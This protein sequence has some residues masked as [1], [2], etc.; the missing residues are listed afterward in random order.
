MKPITYKSIPLF[1]ILVL[2]MFFFSGC[3]ES[4]LDIKPKG[5][6]T[7]D[8]LPKGSLESQVFAAYSGLRSEG[9][10]GLPYVAIHNIRSDDADLGSSAGDEASGGPIFDNFNYPLD[11]WLMNNYWADHYKLINLANIVIAAADSV[12]NPTSTTAEN[13]GEAKFLRAWAYFNLVRAYGE[14][15]LIDF[16]ITDQASANKPK[17]SV[18]AIY[19]LIDADLQSAVSVLPLSWDGYPGRATK[20]MALAVQAKAYIARRMYGQAL[21]S[22]QAVIS[23]GQYDLSVSYDRIFREESENSKESIF[24]IQA[25]YNQ[26]QTEYGITYAS[27]QGVRGSGDWDLGWGWNVPN[28]RLINAFE[29]GDPRKDV[30]VLYSGRINAPYGEVVPTGLPRQYWNKKVYTSPD[31]RKQY[32]SRQGEWFNF[33]VIRYADIVL[34]AAEAAN[35]LGGDSNIDLSLTYLE[36]VRSRARGSNAGILPKVTSR[37]QSTVRTAIRHERQVELGMENERFFDL[38]RWGIDEDTLH[39]AGKTNYQTKN[40][41]LPIPQPE[42]D[43]SGGVLIQN[44]DY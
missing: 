23:S 39:A 33:R 15:P 40:R 8:D 42:I 12:E 2:G 18:S 37:D 38:V 3:K 16:R 43:K 5:R 11:Y 10:S 44:P 14:V 35:E 4:W 13:V 29:D 20:C 34:L 41:Y 22:A 17:S 21:S 36:S 6:F 24:E 19:Q 9:T 30:T 27:R 7:E 31:L 28:T 25:L 32:G 26:S 1:Y